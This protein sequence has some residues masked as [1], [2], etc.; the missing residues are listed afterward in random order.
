MSDKNAA[1]IEF[2]LECPQLKNNK[3]FFNIV[4]ETNDSKQ[5]V[6]VANDRVMHRPYIDGS[7]LKR[8]T[9]T[10]IDFR[11]MMPRPLVENNVE[12]DENVEKLF[13]V[14]SIIDWV[15][16]QADLRNYPDFGVN[17]VIDSMYTTTDNPNLNGIDHSVTPA[18]AKYSVSI[19]IEYID[20]SKRIW[21]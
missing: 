10:I 12:S 6:T 17:C 3:T 13:D 2:L 9:F 11:S 1:V 15:N 18:L 21:N 5:I 8:Y 4:K 14:Q 20:F 19:I 16:E 7:V